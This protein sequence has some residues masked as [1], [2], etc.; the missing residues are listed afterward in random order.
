MRKRDEVMAKDLSLHIGTGNIDGG[1]YCGHSAKLMRAPVKSPRAIMRK[2]FL[3]AGITMSELA[4]N[5]NVMAQA[6]EEN[7]HQ[8]EQVA[9]DRNTFIANLAHEMKTPLTSILGFADILR[10]KRFVSNEE[11]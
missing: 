11:R 8:L 3:F 9:E 4:S 2:D 6:V 1:R 5:M 7:V 10:V